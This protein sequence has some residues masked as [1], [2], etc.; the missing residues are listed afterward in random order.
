MTDILLVQGQRLSLFVPIAGLSTVNRGLRMHI[1][2]V[3][4]APGVRAVLTH[5]GAT[6][7]RVEFA[8]GGVLITLGA[9]ISTAWDL[10]VGTKSVRWVH[11]IESYDLTDADDVIVID[12][13]AVLVR[14][15]A[16]DEQSITAVPALPS[17]VHS[18]VLFDRPQSL[19]T[20]QKAQ[21]RENAGL[22]G[23]TGNVVGPA[24][25][26]DSHIAAF[27]GTTG[28]LIKSG[29][30]TVAGL[31]AAARDRATH[32]GTQLAATISDFASAVGA[33][34]TWSSISGKPSTFT[35]STHASTH[36]TGGG[37]ALTAADIGAAAAS[38]THTI[39]AW[40]ITLGSDATG[41]IYYRN[42]SGMLTRLGIG[43][44]GQVLSVSG[45][46]PAW[47]AASGGSPAGS[48]GQPQ[49]NN[50][51]AFGAMSGVTWDAANGRIGWGTASPEAVVHAVADSAAE[52]PLIA[53]SSSGATAPALEV[54]DS[55]GAVKL[56]IS[57]STGQRII[58]NGAVSAYYHGGNYGLAFGS[59]DLVPGSAGSWTLPLT[60]SRF[61]ANEALVAPQVWF[62][63]LAIG[64]SNKALRGNVVGSNGVVSMDSSGNSYGTLGCSELYLFGS[65][66]SLD[67][68]LSR[69]SAG[70]ITVRNG[71][72][73]GGTLELVAITA[74]ASP[75]AGRVRI[76]AEDN[77]SGKIRLMALFPSGAAQQIAIEP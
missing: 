43:S 35:P 34:L 39:G 8:A 65:G 46:L 28:K 57:S 71:S 4:G 72:T 70:V 58:W 2:D 60:A 6:N 19:T 42:S 56:S 61:Y 27:D 7:A 23:G 45:G 75:S 16:T 55:A 36:A 41:D 20:E 18:A 49:Y 25:A 30:Y 17:F 29:G 62:G 51:G 74:P 50:G 59:T 37:D 76:Y 66:I 14:A 73:G 31:L 24:S 44:S 47:A 10:G 77:G 11:S 22:T 9:T 63:S 13:G 26:T 1:R 52:V 33:L 54:R 32:T 5:N 12:E 40:T 21:F 48:S 67:T 38:H 15:N 69:L 53:Q 68:S 64:S 3:P